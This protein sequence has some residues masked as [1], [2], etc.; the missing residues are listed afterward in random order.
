[1]KRDLSYRLQNLSHRV[2]QFYDLPVIGQTPLAIIPQAIEVDGAMVN[3][4]SLVAALTA[5]ANQQIDVP[6]EQFATSAAA[7][8]TLTSLQGLVQ[9][10]TNGGAV[11]VTLDSAYNIVNQIPNPSNGQ[12]LAFNITTN[13][14]TTVA[15][16]TLSDTAVTL[17]GTT[18][19]LAAA[20]RWYQ[21]QITQLFTTSGAAVT[22]GTTFTSIAQ[23]GST[24]NF[25]VTLATNAIVPV[26]GQVI[27]L[28]V[29]AGTA[30]TTL[31]SGWYPINKVTSA[32]SFVI[33]TPPGTVWTA[34]AATV[35]GTILV[36][37]SQFTPGSPLTGG[38]GSIGVYSPLMNVTGLM[39]TVTGT[40][41][42]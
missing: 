29:T 14:A 12:T 35:P 9:R 39:A 25:T 30:G 21:G 31:P 28:N 7:S 5:F 26:V 33:A 3:A 8:L 34:T 24:N 20:M 38:A 22:A 6:G 36:P 11:T 27:F 41:S 32:T 17:V 19:V 16:P 4:A 15:T 2:R 37:T 23:V 42:V 18:T 10:L 40:M 13:A 1:M